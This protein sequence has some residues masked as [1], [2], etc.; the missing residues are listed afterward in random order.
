[1]TNK[2]EKEY[3]DQISSLNFL[4]LEQKDQINALGNER[5]FWKKTAQ[6]L[7]RIAGFEIPDEDGPYFMAEDGKL[8]GVESI[9]EDWLKLKNKKREEKNHDSKQGGK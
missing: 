6:E 1:M 2:Q 8:V 7:L 9:R 3:Q 5:D 4:L